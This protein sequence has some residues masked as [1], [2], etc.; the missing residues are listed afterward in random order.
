MPTIRTTIINFNLSPQGDENNEPIHSI[1]SLSDFNLSP[2]GDENKIRRNRC[3]VALFQ[4]IPARGRKQIKYF[5]SNLATE[6]FNLSPQGDE[7]LESVENAHSAYNISTYPRK[8][9]KTS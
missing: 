5:K 4:L 7:N 6:D 8:G 1:V 2:Q 3:A 9:T